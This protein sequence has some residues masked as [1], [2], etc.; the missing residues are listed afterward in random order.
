[1]K[2]FDLDKMTPAQLAELKAQL[3]EK[4]KAEKE[5]IRKERESYKNIVTQT[6]KEQF[7]KLQNLSSELSLLKAD[8]YGQFASI[9]ELKNE[10]YGTKSG[11]A[12]HTFTDDEGRS[13]TIGYR[14]IESF[15][16]TL[17]MGIAKVREYIDSLAVDEN[18][19]RLVELVNRLLKKDA[20]GNLKA[21]RVLDLQ[22]LADKVQNPLLIEG[23]TI[24]REAYKPSRSS[25][26]IEA[27]VKDL[28]NTG[29]SVPVPLS[30][31]SVDFPAGTNIRMEV[32]K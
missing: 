14:Q 7:V 9:I 26:F 30:I 23:V 24:I 27:E 10:L 5:H 16:D 8:I 28:A 11:Q 1:M 4:E 21:N 15:D 12:S 19:A 13:I 3:A 18:S 22:N 2:Q 31:T 32:F 17:D 6:V 29:Q 20:K 25:I